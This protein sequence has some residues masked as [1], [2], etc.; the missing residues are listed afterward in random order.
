MQALVRAARRVASTGVTLTAVAAGLVA[1]AALVGGS[2]SSA[3]ATSISQNAYVFSPLDRFRAESLGSP[4]TNRATRGRAVRRKASPGGFNWEPA[5]TL[6]HARSR[7]GMAFFP[8][9][10]RFYAL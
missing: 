2:A 3:S 9:N 6:N 10:G 7:L 5:G 1:V 4:E 8:G